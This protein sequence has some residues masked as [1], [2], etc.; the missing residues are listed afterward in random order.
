[1]ESLQ[2]HVIKLLST[3]KGRKCIHVIQVFIFTVQSF[4]LNFYYLRNHTK[5]LKRRNSSALHLNTLNFFFSNENINI[6]TLQKG[7]CSK[8]PK[9]LDVELP[10]GL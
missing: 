4:I 6:R 5:G 3:E 10:K 7:W 2:P 1:M 8:N 9:I